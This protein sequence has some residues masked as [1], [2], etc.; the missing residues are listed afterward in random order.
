M[1]KS[2]K[3]V[4]Q[5]ANMIEQ[6]GVD[7]IRIFLLSDTPPEKDIE[8]TQSGSEGTLRFINRVISMGERVNQIKNLN[9]NGYFN[10]SYLEEIKVFMNKTIDKVKTRVEKVI[11]KK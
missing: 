7:T 6:Y 10:E 8:W 11:E 4:I 3:N 9:L 2:K 1:S 5:A